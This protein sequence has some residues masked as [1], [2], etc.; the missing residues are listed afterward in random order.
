MGMELDVAKAE[1]FAGKMLGVVNGAFVGLMTSIGH[2]TGLFDTM[3]GL[4]AASSAEIAT[5][6]KLNERYVRE[7]LASM[8]TAQIVEYDPAAHTYRL[9]PEHA[10][11]LTSAAG[12]DNLAAFTQYVALAA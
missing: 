2:Q 8:V 12:P 11:C 6:A 10:V 5:A 4:S 7:W 3:A 9:P 1:A